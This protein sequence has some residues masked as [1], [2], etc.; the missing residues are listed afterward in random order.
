[1]KKVKLRYHL[2][3][4][5]FLLVGFSCS[6][7]ADP[8]ADIEAAR[9]SAIVGTWKIKELTLAYPIKFGGQNLPV[10]FDIFSIAPLLP[11]SG[12]KIV[13]AKEN[14]YTFSADNNYAIS[15]CTDLVFA[16]TEAAGKW[17]FELNGG[18]LKLS[19]STDKMAPFLTTALSKSVWTISNTI[20]V[21]EANAAVPVNIILEK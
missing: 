10:G 6:K 1:M 3:V 16:G 21:A 9:K 12:P 15:G 19:T 13:C 17:G 20:F 7:D 5:S 2:L 11:V 18:I 4:L 8:S 14:T